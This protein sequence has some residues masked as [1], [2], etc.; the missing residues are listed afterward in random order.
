[1]EIKRADRGFWI[2]EDEN[3]PLALIE[4]RDLGDGNL[5]VIST[6]VDSSL[7]GQ[8][9]AKILLDHLVTYARAENIKLKAVCSYVVKKFDEDRS[10]DDVNL[11]A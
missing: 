2:G 10:Y 11:E 3:S 5:A 1:M 4:Y 8:G 9:V 7:R 6:K